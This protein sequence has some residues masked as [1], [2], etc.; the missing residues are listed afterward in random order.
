MLWSRWYYL[1]KKV[2]SVR[3]YLRISSADRISASGGESFEGFWGGG[4]YMIEWGHV[5]LW[6][7][8]LDSW[9]NSTRQQCSSKFCTCYSSS[10]YI[11]WKKW[12]QVQGCRVGLTFHW[13]DF[14]LSNLKM[15]DFPKTS[16]AF[17]FSSN[18]TWIYS[19]ALHFRNNDF[20][21]L[22]EVKN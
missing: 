22:I 14:L 4:G 16:L 12:L 18:V 9:W 19:F 6:S 5:W 11:S 21:I 8:L 3:G 15:Y 20:Q 1:E 2:F 17:R 7:S 10:E 13:T